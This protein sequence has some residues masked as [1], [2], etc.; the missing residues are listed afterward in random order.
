MTIHVLSLLVAILVQQ[1]GECKEGAN[2]Q[3]EVNGIAYRNLIH[4]I[5]LASVSRWCREREVA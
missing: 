5:I 3:E 4:G 2:P 1:S